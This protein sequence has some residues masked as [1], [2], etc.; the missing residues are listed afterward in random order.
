MLYANSEN[1]ERIEPSK[2]AK[3]FCPFCGQK[4]KAICGEIYVHHWRHDSLEN[5]DS[6]YENETD[7]HRNWKKEFPESWREFIVSRN[8]K[9]HI[10]DIRTDNEFVLELQNSSISKTTIQ[11]R[12]K[13]YGKMVWLINAESFKENFSIYSVVTSKLRQLENSY[14]YEYLN[15]GDENVFLIEKDIIEDL[16][17]DLQQLYWNIEKSENEINKYDNY[18]NNID[19]AYD[20]IVRNIS[21]SELSDFKSERLNELKSFQQKI[22]E[23]NKAENENNEQKEKINQLRNCTVLDYENYKVV[24]FEQVSPKSFALCKVIESE[25]INSFFPVVLNVESE[26]KFSSLSYQNE[27]YTLIIDL[28]SKETK[29]NK[30]IEDLKSRKVS[31]QNQ[32]DDVNILIKKEIVSFLQKMKEIENV[33]ALSIK[34]ELENKKSQLELAENDLQNKLSEQRKAN[35]AYSAQLSIEKKEEEIDIKRT[36]K[37]CYTYN[38]KH[39]RKTWDYADCTVFMDFGSHIFEIIDKQNLKKIDKNEFIERIKNWR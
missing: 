36:Y 37:K 6:W 11:I 7:W 10:A 34:E 27:K 38:W 1:N 26:Y 3:A 18:L 12:E 17:N 31:L 20:E 4:V 5:C 32:I 8:G 25:T 29:L 13:F 35:E 39:R 30:Q 14:S 24:D 21:W 16:N 19:A 2:G 9:K 22:D 23:I 15:S 33:E 28:S